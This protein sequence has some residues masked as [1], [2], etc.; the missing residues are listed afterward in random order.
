MRRS[1]LLVAFCLAML[2]NPAHA[3]NPNVFRRLF[4]KAKPSGPRQPFPGIFANP[5]LIN[6]AAR[7]LESLTRHE[8]ETNRGPYYP[9]R[10]GQW[11]AYGSRLPEQLL[12][13]DTWFVYE[14]HPTEFSTLMHSAV[15]EY[16]DYFRAIHG[17]EAWSQEKRRITK[18]VAE[19]TMALRSDFGNQ[20]G[21][22]YRF[23]PA[24]H[25]ARDPY[26]SIN[27]AFL[28]PTIAL[29]AARPSD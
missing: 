29:Y 2:C 6:Q 26:R 28:S 22:A 15:I 10:N 25:L 21:A 1:L 24:E 3:I 7:S 20:G 5:R 9:Y 14:T 27:G 17:E 13:N 8:E 12:R 11:S 23:P 16:G 18:D 4:P 19:C